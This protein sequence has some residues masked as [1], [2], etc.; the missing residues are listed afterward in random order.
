M[1]QEKFMQIYGEACIRIRLLEEEVVRLTKEKEACKQ[2]ED[3]K[4]Q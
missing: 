2:G 4:K 3:G 1:E